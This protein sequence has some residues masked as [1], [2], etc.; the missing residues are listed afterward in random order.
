M[1]FQINR[2]LPTNPPFLI[3]LAIVFSVFIMLISVTESFSQKDDSIDISVVNSSFIQ[4][5]KTDAN[6]VKVNLEYTLEKEKLQNQL[7]NAVMEV[8]APN[9]T[10]IRT[11]STASGFTLQRDGGEQLLKTSLQDKSL[12]T[13]SIKIMLTDLSKKI[14]LSNTIT[15]ELKLEDDST[16]N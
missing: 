15:D 14:P 8:Y 4:L 12:Q 9:G 5:S 2:F 1:D 16:T 10:L 6:Q 13:V 7:V 11:T 3:T